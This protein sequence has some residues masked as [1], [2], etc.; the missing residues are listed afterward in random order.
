MISL[1]HNRQV[2][3]HISRRPQDRKG[4]ITVLCDNQYNRH[5]TC[6]AVSCVSILLSLEVCV[7]LSFV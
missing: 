7:T 5:G 4:H 2:Y 6:A 3:D 1:I